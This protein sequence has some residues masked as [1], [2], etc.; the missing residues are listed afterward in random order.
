MAIINGPAGTGEIVVH[1]KGFEIVITATSDNSV[2]AQLEYAAILQSNFLSTTLMIRRINLRTPGHSVVCR[3]THFANLSWSL[4]V[5]NSSHARSR[6]SDR[7]CV[8]LG[9]APGGGQRSRR[10]KGYA[11]S[12]EGCRSCRRRRQRSCA[13]R[14]DC[15]TGYAGVVV[16]ETPRTAVC[17][18]E[19]HGFNS[20]VQD[21]GPAGH[22]HGQRSTSSLTTYLGSI[23][24]RTTGNGVSCE[25]TAIQLNMSCARNR[26]WCSS[27]LLIGKDKI[28]ADVQISA[29]H[30]QQG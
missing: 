26:G 10:A 15:F 21:E 27:S 29:G 18:N 19:T 16:Q 17:G 13:G 22:V 28:S 23:I 1:F 12:P 25:C 9:R 4:R 3:N 20:I 30:I 6:A 5:K 7:V 8:Y 11:E 14:D 24:C 2:T